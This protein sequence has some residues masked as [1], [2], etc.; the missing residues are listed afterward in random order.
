ML[1]FFWS[2][3]PHPESTN[4]VSITSL[5]GLWSSKRSPQTSFFLDMLQVALRTEG[6]PCSCILLVVLLAITWS[7]HD[8][9]NPCFPDEKWTTHRL[10]DNTAP[11]SCTAVI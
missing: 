5:L 2:K 4:P 10:Q 3:V 7:R 8:R 9:K 11:H 1:Y 6:P